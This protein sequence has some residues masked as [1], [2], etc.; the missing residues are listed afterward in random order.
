MKAQ[1]EPT[2][3]ARRIKAGSAAGATGYLVLPSDSGYNDVVSNATKPES[4]AMSSDANMPET[5]V[6]N[7]PASEPE[8][9]GM[10][11]NTYCM[12]LHLS[13]L[14]DC[15]APPC[16]IIAPIV[17]WAIGK[18][19][20]VC[21]DQHGKVVLNWTISCIIYLFVCLPLCLL[22]IGIPLL[23]ALVVLSIVF[24]IIGAVK[25]ND[26]IVWKYPLSIEFFR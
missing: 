3:Q 17:M 1:T 13:Q 10:K 15:C 14:L 9:F 19:K 8:V 25:A 21:V 4:T 2:A 6:Q 5:N 24:P 18:D 11:P 7:V 22:L 12:L 26:G 20:N 23:L 16:G